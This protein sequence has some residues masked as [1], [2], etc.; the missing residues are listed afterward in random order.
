MD[1]SNKANTLSLKTN[2][3]IIINHVNKKPPTEL[4]E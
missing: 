4:K 1:Q 2:N 3:F